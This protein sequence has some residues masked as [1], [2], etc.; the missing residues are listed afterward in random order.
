MKGLTVTDSLQNTAE[1]ENCYSTQ[2]W[3]P[4]SIRDD[5]ACIKHITKKADQPGNI[6]ECC[7]MRYLC[8]VTEARNTKA[9]GVQAMVQQIIITRVT[10]QSF[11]S[12]LKW[13]LVSFDAFL[14]FW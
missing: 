12:D 1:M 14:F 3:E 7:V 9:Y 11:F 8:P 4:G 2:N 6:S 10:F 13:K 5:V